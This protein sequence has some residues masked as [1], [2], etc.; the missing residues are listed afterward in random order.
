MRE[1]KGDSM[2]IDIPDRLKFEKLPLL[3]PCYCGQC[4]R[5]LTD[6]RVLDNK[7]AWC[8]DCKEIVNSSWFQT[9]SWTIG[10]TAVLYMTQLFQ[11]L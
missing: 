1:S 4:K 8:P 11:L 5:P 7:H 3:S 6:S 10:A 2:K 9:K